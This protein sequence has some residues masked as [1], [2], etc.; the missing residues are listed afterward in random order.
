MMMLLSTQVLLTGAFLSFS[1]YPSHPTSHI[2]IQAIRCVLE[3]QNKPTKKK[4]K[5]VVC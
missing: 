1:L 4:S 3:F 2:P 5:C